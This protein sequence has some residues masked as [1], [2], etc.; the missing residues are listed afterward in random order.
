MALGPG[1]S[2]AAC[3][4]AVAFSPALLVATTLTVNTTDDELNSDGDCSLREA[5]RAANLDSAMD[6]CGTGSGQDTIIIPEGTY[7]LSLAGTG[8]DAAA[9]GDL[10]ITKAV[11]IFGAG[12]DATLLSAGELDRI[13]HIDAEIT[14]GISGLTLQGG[15]A[16]TGGAIWNRGNLTLAA[17]ILRNN[18]ATEDGG[19]LYLVAP[20]TTIVRDSTFLENQ[21]TLDGG[22]VHAENGHTLKIRNSTLSA[23]Q[24]G[25]D[26]GA[27]S[28]SSSATQVFLSN[29]TVYQNE[30]DSDNSGSGDGGGIYQ[31][32]AVITLQNSIVA[33]NSV[34][35]GGLSP[36]CDGSFLSGAYNLIQ[37][38]TEC[39]FDVTTGHQTGL[40]PLLE[41][42]ADYGGPTLTHAVAQSSPVLDTGN[43]SACTDESGVTLST[44]QRGLGFTRSFDGNG[45]DTA[46]C[47]LGAFESICGDGV[48]SGDEACDDGDDN[49]DVLADTCRSSTCGTASCGDGVVD[50]GEECD[51]GSSNSDVLANTCRTTC[52]NYFVGDAVVDAGEACDDGNQV[53]GDGCEVAGALPTC[54]NGVVDS[55]EE[56]DNGSSNSDILA[57]ACRTTCVQAA[58]GDGIVDTGEACDD[59]NANNSDACIVTVSSVGSGTTTSAAVA[60]CSDGHVQAGVEECDDGVANSDTVADACR[61]DCTRA[62][63]G[64][65]VVDTA[66]GEECDDGNVQDGDGCSSRGRLEVLGSLSADNP[67]INFNDLRVGDAISLQTPDPLGTASSALVTK[68][69]VNTA[70]CTC[71]WS[72]TPAEL[73]TYD[74]QKACQAALLLAEVGV[75]TLQV[76]V[77]CHYLGTGTFEQAVTVVEGTESSGRT[78]GGSGGSVGGGGCSLL[79]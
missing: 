32:R 44:D 64:D 70:L 61:T 11:S 60:S 17:V 77:D 78:G 22:A 26:G 49:S 59:G 24:A 42:L 34:G 23:N 3:L 20:T 73:G 45:D 21:A 25:N 31:N 14:V 6:A 69:A 52:Q 75:G 39:V 66:A 19:A 57:D 65:A 79:Q 51:N 40:D 43:P 12:A 30:A 36:D 28:S 15:L 35:S 27:I 74:D 9:T 47:D 58:Q 41:I 37:D 7:T 72:I 50:S 5:V 55:G 54:G 29:V 2:A 76:A 18:E 53:S 62:S 46:R 71:A 48:I 8:E 16:D 4:L 38:N 1:L 33:G 56:C 68:A 10:D 63:I 67:G 13:F